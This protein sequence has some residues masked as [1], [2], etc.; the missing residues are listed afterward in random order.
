MPKCRYCGKDIKWKFKYREVPPGEK[1][2]PLNMD[3]S[4]HDCRPKPIEKIEQDVKT[5]QQ[6]PI[7][8]PPAP[9]P[10][11]PKSSVQAGKEY[12]E[13]RFTPADKITDIEQVVSVLRSIDQTLKNI[14]N[15]LQTIS[16]NTGEE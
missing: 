15:C 5:S 12:N 8:T 1:N 10:E 4:L 6:K 13:P 16:R 2:L 3:G 11:Q 9:P 14:N 7:I